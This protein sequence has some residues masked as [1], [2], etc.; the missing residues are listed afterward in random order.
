[1]AHAAHLAPT[2][3]PERTRVTR[4]PIIRPGTA[5]WEEREANRLAREWRV[6]TEQRSQWKPERPY[7]TIKR[8]DCYRV[9]TVEQWGDK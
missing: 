1:M 4:K 3:G 5:M 6:R 8:F 9:P 7:R 2:V